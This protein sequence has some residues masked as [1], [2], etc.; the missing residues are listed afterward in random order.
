M[1]QFVSDFS[2]ILGIEKYWVSSYHPAYFFGLIYR[3][4]NNFETRKKAM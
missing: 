3:K 1:T 2:T 4:D